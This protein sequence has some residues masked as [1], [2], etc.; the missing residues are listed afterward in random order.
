MQTLMQSFPSKIDLWL[1]LVLLLTILVCLWAAFDSA[2]NGNLPTAALVLILGAGL[3]LW[4]L[5]TTRYLVGEGQLIVK[6]GPFNWQIVLTAID[7]VEPSRNP[8][9]SPALSLDRLAI[10]YNNGRQIL[11]SPR[12]QQGFREAIGH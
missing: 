10:H 2:R 9:S 7:R 8:M 5:M 6:S 3:P 12:D 4:L 1:L 11:V